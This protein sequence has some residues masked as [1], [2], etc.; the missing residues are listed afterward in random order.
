MNESNMV[1]V[2]HERVEH[3]QGRTWMWSRSNRIFRCAVRPCSTLF[4]HVR[5]CSCSTWL[6]SP[7]YIKQLLLLHEE[8]I[9]KI[10]TNAI[11][12]PVR[13]NLNMVEHGRTRSNTVERGRTAHL[14]FLFDLD[15][16]HVR[17]WPCSTTFMFDHRLFL[18]LKLPVS[19]KKIYRNPC[20]RSKDTA[21]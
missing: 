5:P 16:V 4:D 7:S 1:K 11:A 13:S 9:L 2:E 6:V 8:R 19:E 20:S 12:R 18:R 17:P 3:G 14:K 21:S 10:Y 15:H